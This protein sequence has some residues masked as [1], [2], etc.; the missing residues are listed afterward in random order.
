MFMKPLE[1]VLVVDLFEPMLASLLRLLR[2]LSEREWSL[3]TPCEGWTV[4]DVALHLLGDEFGQLSRGR[5]KDASSLLPPEPDLVS[6]IN[7][8]NQLWVEAARRMSPRLI[9]DLLD[10][11][12]LEVVRYFKGLHLM[13]IDGP[14]SWAGPDP[15]PVWFDVAREYTEHWHHQQH[16]REAVQQPGLTEAAFL[17]PVLDTFVRALPWTFRSVEAPEQTVVELSVV[18]DAGKSWFLMRKEARWSLFA[19]TPYVPAATV[20]LDQEIAWRL[21]TKGIAREKAMGKASMQGNKE[22]AAKIFEAI[23]IIA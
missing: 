17:S 5:D 6:R 8:Q 2:Q 16:I 3:A 19:E 11:A 15:A 1:P 9:C 22:L 14:V 20:R 18:G 4:K 12:G 21:F 7:A 10:A 13:D 23:A